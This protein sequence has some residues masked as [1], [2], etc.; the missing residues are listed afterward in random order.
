MRKAVAVISIV[1]GAFLVLGASAARAQQAAQTPKF[2]ISGFRVEG[3]TVLPKDEVDQALQPQVGKGRDFADVQRALEALQAAYQR[4]GYGGVYVYLPEQRLQGGAVVLKVIEARLDKIT[5]TGNRHFSEASVRRALPDLKPGTVPN[6]VD[7][8]ENS[9]AANENP[10]RQLRVVLKPSPTEGRIDAAVEVADHNPFKP[11]VS[12]DNTGTPSTGRA[13]LG[14]GLQYAN[15]WQRDHVATL[16]YITSPT[17]RDKVKVYSLGYRFAIP[18]WGDSVDLYAGYSDVS[19]AQTQT[20]AGPLSISGKGTLAGARYNLILRRKGEYE[21]RVLFGADYRRF[22]NQCSLG[23]FGAAGCV[24]TG[25]NPGADVQTRPV[26]LGYSGQLI[27]ATRQAGFN[28]SVARNMPGGSGGEQADFAA[29]RAAAKAD[30]QLLRYGANASSQV[31]GG[32][33]TLRANYQGQ[34]TSDALLPAE[35]FGV[36]G[37]SAVRGFLEREVAGDRGMFGNLE[38]YSPD[39]GSSRG[40]KALSARML[41][42]VDG[43]AAWIN[44]PVLGQWERDGVASWGLGMR[45]SYGRNLSLR[46]DA[47]SVLRPGGSRARGDKMAHAGMVASF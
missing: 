2:D 37:F 45:A 34:H 38:L 40:A 12:L 47:A 1:A 8:A 5:V 15:L 17:E 43:G 33:W 25:G 20:P 22:D 18:S 3:N 30:Y 28:L 14:F 26:S 21:Q 29:V 27:Q 23:V 32:A 6:M 31:F 35:Q 7:I 19:A 42:F 36:V 44:Q 16:Q 10:A 13:R 4:R 41:A 9:R 24:S 46:L 11:F 39:V